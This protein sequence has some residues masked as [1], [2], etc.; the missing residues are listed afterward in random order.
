[1]LKVNNSESFIEDLSRFRHQFGADILNSCLPMP[2]TMCADLLMRTMKTRSSKVSGTWLQDLTVQDS[3]PV[4]DATV[5]FVFPFSKKSTDPITITVGD[6]RRLNH[7]E[8]LNDNIIDLRVRIIL[9]KIDVSIYAQ[10]C[11]ERRI[12][13]IIHTEILPMYAFS[14]HFFTA[15]VEK[16]RGAERVRAMTKHVN[17]FEKE[18][19]FMPINESGHWSLL[20]IVRPGILAHQHAENAVFQSRATQNR[21][22]LIHLD[23]LSTH[24][25]SIFDPIYGFLNDEFAA[26]YGKSEAVFTKYS[27]P[28]VQPKNVRQQANGVDCGVYVIAFVDYVVKN[29]ILSTPEDLGNSFA[30]FFSAFKF[31]E[32]D[33]NLA[34]DK[35]LKDLS[36]LSAAYRMRKEWAQERR[37]IRKHNETSCEMQPTT[38]AGEIE[39][40]VSNA[41]KSE[42]GKDYLYN[43]AAISNEDSSIEDESTD[44]TSNIIWSVGDSIMQPCSTVNAETEQR[45]Q[46]S[47][48]SEGSITFDSRKMRCNNAHSR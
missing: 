10:M 42:A 39:N 25:K 14:C 30:S 15:L 1:M 41:K 45:I 28:I 3:F 24:K 19:I 35:F 9:K 16:K 26:R 47:I 7:G 8:W 20:C 4:A 46:E 33:A 31:S 27:C 44:V 2:P 22:C 32:D 40:I 29:Q 17:I 48:G 11:S 36:V 18:F 13:P 6:Q 5:L 43:D 12:S 21:S 37:L 38:K 23:S 34:R